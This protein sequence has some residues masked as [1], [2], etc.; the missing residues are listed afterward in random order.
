MNIV[1]K[2]I[3]LMEE[4]KQ[5]VENDKINGIPFAIKAFRSEIPIIEKGFYVGITAQTKGGKSKFLQYC[6]VN[7]PI[8]Y[9]YHNPDKIRIKILY[10]ALEDTPEEITLQ[11]MSYLLY[12]LS[13]K[14]I[15]VS[16]TELKSSDKEHMLTDEILALL[17]SD[18]YKKILDFYAEHVEF[19]P[20]NNNVGIDI[21]IK[22]YAEAHG[23]CEYES[24]TYEDKI[25]GRITTDKKL[26]K[27]TPNDP[28]EYVIPIVD[29]VSLVVPTINDGGI[30]G[31]IGN[32]SKNM[33]YIK[34]KFNYIP[35]IVQQQASAETGGIE[36][37]KTGNIR[38]TKAGLSD[39]K[40]TGN[41]VTLLFGITNPYSFEYPSY[42][43]Y[44]ITKLKDNFRV[45]EVILNRHGKSNGL[46]PLFFD[47][48][49]NFF[50]PLPSSSDMDGLNL[51]YN[52]INSIARKVVKKAYTFYSFEKVN[53]LKRLIM[54]IKYHLYDRTPSAKT[55][56]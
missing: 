17:K 25:T 47:G 8:L 14:K 22:S 36:A 9:A 1:D 2:T 50:T 26:V 49:V 33:V 48:A 4:R 24:F 32:L 40:S 42:L 16:P 5:R 41:D 11:F 38:P 28:D 20:E 21:K 37:R 51:I 6:F 7:F 18:E 55:K 45:M 39:C 12:Q 34:N 46:C 10:F 56:A 30:K 27:Y 19:C 35:I 31:A 15:R 43:G 53:P 52:H 44:D 23:K 3:A 54:K 13:D 29:H